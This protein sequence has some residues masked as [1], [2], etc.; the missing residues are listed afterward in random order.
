M[1]KG[2][3]FD[4]D[5]LLFDTEQ[6]Y[7]Q[8]WHKAAQQ[9]GVTISNDFCYAVSG[10]SGEGMLNIIRHHVPAADP[11]QLRDL[12]LALCEEEQKKH[13]PEKPGIHQ[14]L[15]YFHQNGLKIAVA[16]SS[17]K[18]QVERN[19][20]TAGIRNYF[21]AVV[22]GQ[23]V[24]HGKPHPEIF[25]RAAAELGLNPE[26]CYV[27]EDSFNGVRAGHAAGCCTVMIPDLVQPNEEL[28]QQYDFCC[29]DF[30]QVL[31][32]LENDEL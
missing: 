22:S 18:A 2:A 21:D 3:I 12:C 20:T 1:K 14:I 25:Q 13:L 24:T 5:G 31:N 30:F 19:L 17:P 15:E 16:S 6:L 8:S 28:S 29:Q 26:D 9:L 4:Q 32:K 23:E 10:S 27:F 11:E 7:F